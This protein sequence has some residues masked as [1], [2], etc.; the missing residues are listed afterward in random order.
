MTKLIKN[1]GKFVRA[2]EL[3]AGTEMESKMII[4]GKIVLNHV[5]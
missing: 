1:K 2:Y 3:G 4:E 5:R